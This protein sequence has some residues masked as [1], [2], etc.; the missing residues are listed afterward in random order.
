MT[1]K[2]VPEAICQAQLVS[3]VQ[4]FNNDPTV[5]GILIQLPLP[6]GLDEKAVTEAVDVT[7]DVDGYAL[8]R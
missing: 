2:R 8:E 3:M 5:H 7:K 6:K 4:K 1:L